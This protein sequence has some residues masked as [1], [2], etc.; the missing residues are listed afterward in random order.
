MT[1]WKNNNTLESRRLVEEVLHPSKKARKSRKIVVTSFPQ[2]RDLIDD[3][4]KEFG[5][6]CDLNDIDVSQ[7]TDMS[8]LFK[9]SNFNGDIS[10][11]DVSNVIDMSHMFYGSKFNGDIS[12]WNVS[13]VTDMRHMFDNSPLKGKEPS[14]YEKNPRD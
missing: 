4:V 1:S 8:G 7:I 10:Q 9:Y 6:N 12:Q 14:W 3:R 11:W 5:P 2:L 13:K